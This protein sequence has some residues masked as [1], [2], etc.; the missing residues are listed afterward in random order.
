MCRKPKS[1]YTCLVHVETAEPSQLSGVYGNSKIT[2]VAWQ[3]YMQQCMQNYKSHHSCLVRCN[4]KE[5]TEA[6][7]YACPNGGSAETLELD[8]SSLCERHHHPHTQDPLSGAMSIGTR[9]SCLMYVK[10]SPNSIATYA[11]SKSGV[12]AIF[13]FALSS[14]CDRRQQHCLS[15]LLS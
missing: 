4:H 1:D 12:A 5:T 9:L 6:A 2:A 3:M 7:T 15:E 14:F 8:L 11:C 10:T 13:E